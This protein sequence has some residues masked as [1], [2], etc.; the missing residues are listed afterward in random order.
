M[1]RTR[2]TPIVPA[3][4]L[5]LVLALVALSAGPAG[6]ARTGPG[7]HHDNEI[8][9]LD[10]EIGIGGELLDG[11]FG[12]QDN[13]DDSDDDDRRG[14]FAQ[15]IELLETDAFEEL[16]GAAVELVDE[17]VTETIVEVR[18]AIIAAIP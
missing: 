7:P 16:V 8:T 5:A 9:P 11:L 3:L 15:L 10:V 2:P 1:S 13:D 6:A 17:G 12:D 14:V 4:G 18:D